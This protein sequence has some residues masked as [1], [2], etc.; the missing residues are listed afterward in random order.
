M[1]TFS[2]KSKVQLQCIW[3]L[4]STIFFFDRYQSKSAEVNSD[5]KIIHLCWSL[6]AIPND[7]TLPQ[8]IYYLQMGPPTDKDAT[9][10][11]VLILN[12]P[13]LSDMHRIWSLIAM[14]HQQVQHFE[15]HANFLV[16]WLTDK[17]IFSKCFYWTIEN[18]HPAVY[19]LAMFLWN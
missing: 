2:M 4:H 14:T 15:K 8:Q 13:T 10:P 6:T 7:N 17:F 12:E 11:R 16:F 3:S 9:V 1:P 5:T 19:N 18:V